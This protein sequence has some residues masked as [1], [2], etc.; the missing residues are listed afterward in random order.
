MNA[1]S[2]PIYSERLD[3]AQADAFAHAFPGI[4]I[5]AH[6]IAKAMAPGGKIFDPDAGF[7][8]DATMNHLRAAKRRWP[9]IRDPLHEGHPVVVALQASLAERPGDI[10]EPDPEIAAS[11]EALG[12]T[13]IGK[14]VHCSGVPIPAG[15]DQVTYFVV[16]RYRP[17][18][19]PLADPAQ[20]YRGDLAYDAD[21][22]TDEMQ[23][24]VMLMSTRFHR[25]NLIHL[26][27]SAPK[28]Y[29]AIWMRDLQA[30]EALVRPLRASLLP[31]SYARSRITD[32]RR[33]LLIACDIMAEYERGFEILRELKF[34]GGVT[35]RSV[36]L[37]LPPGATM[38][39]VY[40][41][42][43]NTH[44]HIAAGAAH[45][46]SVHP[47][48][49][50]KAPERGTDAVFEQVRS[51]FGN[52][53]VHQNHYRSILTVAGDLPVR[54]FLGVEP[55]RLM[56]VMLIQMQANLI[57]HEGKFWEAG[58][59]RQKVDEKGA[60]SGRLMRLAIVIT[61]NICLPTARA[62]MHDDGIMRDSVWTARKLVPLIHNPRMEEE[63]VQHQCNTPRVPRALSDRDEF[64]YPYEE[65][66]KRA[67]KCSNPIGGPGWTQ[68]FRFDAW[69]KPLAEVAF[70]GECCT[71]VR[72]D[73]SYLPGRRKWDSITGRVTKPNGKPVTS[74]EVPT[75]F[76]KQHL[77]ERVQDLFRPQ[78]DRLQAHERVLTGEASAIGLHR[79]AL[80]RDIALMLPALSAITDDPALHE[81][82]KM[83][84]DKTNLLIAREGAWNS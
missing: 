4:M 51:A 20:V 23:E 59:R 22:T 69:R 64:K 56:P 62:M 41:V 72:F 81:R 57:A 5:Y 28:L 83:L 8:T 25:D 65:A 32:L 31:Q 73:A 19:S 29:M 74:A 52:S 27:A 63:L 38:A 26:A 24:S 55:A 50:R 11:L 30:A 44:C 80:L 3:Q 45:M 6:P 2:T 1:H 14:V 16:L 47:T 13:R 79:Q 17:L 10:P 58:A 37:A 43:D 34:I 35:R 71:Y 68:G 82:F 46:R 18:F 7:V 70:L 12:C 84:E 9:G 49:N 67:K 53:R 78:F 75:G 54:C 77:L 36:R 48:M 40:A 21:H 33:R 42:D 15:P 39:S 61:S 76:P 66:R 60:M